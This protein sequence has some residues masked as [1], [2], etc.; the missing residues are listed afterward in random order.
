M[1]QVWQQKY[2]SNQNQSISQ[3]KNSKIQHQQIHENLSKNIEQKYQSNQKSKQYVSGYS[4]LK[5]AVQKAFSIRQSPRV[6]KPDSVSKL[7]NSSSKISLQNIEQLNNQN[8]Q[9]FYQEK[10]I[11]P[12]QHQ[13]FAKAI[14]NQLSQISHREIKVKELLGQSKMYQNSS[15]AS[16]A[17]DLR[18][19]QRDYYQ[20]NVN[21]GSSSFRLM[22]GRQSPENSCVIKM[23][24]INYHSHVQQESKLQRSQM[25]DS[26]G[27]SD[28]N[29]SH[30]NSPYQ[31]NL[32]SCQTS[33]KNTSLAVNQFD[34]AFEKFKQASNH[35]QFKHNIPVSM[36]Q[37]NSSLNS[38]RNYITPYKSTQKQEQ[39]YISTR[40]LER[41]VSQ[42][43]L[44]NKSKN[45]LEMMRRHTPSGAKTIRSSKSY[46]N[47][48][49]KNKNQCRTARPHQNSRLPSISSHKSLKDVH[50]KNSGILKFD[51]FQKERFGAGISATN[52]NK[53]I[54][55]Y[56]PIPIKD[57]SCQNF[58][59]G[60][61]FS[62]QRQSI[63]SFSPQKII[64]NKFQQ[65]NQL[66]Q[67]I[68][69][70]Q[71]QE[72]L[73][74]VEDEHEMKWHDKQHI[75][76]LQ[77]IQLLH[78][79]KSKLSTQQNH[80]LK[81][82]KLLPTQSEAMTSQNT[83]QLEKIDQIQLQRNIQ[84]TR[85]NQS[86]RIFSL[87]NPNSTG[88][89]NVTPL[90]QN[91]DHSQAFAYLSIGNSSN[92]LVQINEANSF[93]VAP[94]SN[95]S[96]FSYNTK[97]YKPNSN[98]N[99]TLKNSEQIQTMKEQSLTSSKTKIASHSDQINTKQ[100]NSNKNL[101]IQQ[102]LD[103]STNLE[104]SQQ[105]QNQRL[106][107][108]ENSQNI[109][110]QRNYS[111]LGGY[112]QNGNK[113]LKNQS[114]VDFDNVQSGDNHLA[115]YR[116]NIPQNSI[117]PPYGYSRLYHPSSTNLLLNAGGSQSHLRNR[118]SLL[119][120][121]QGDLSSEVIMFRADES[122]F[123]DELRNSN[124]RSSMNIGMQGQ[125]FSYK[126]KLDT[127][128]V[129]LSNKESEPIDYY[130]DL[131]NPSINS[132][133][134]TGH[135]NP[136]D[137]SKPQQSQIIFRNKIS[138]Q[139]SQKILQS[140]NPYQSSKFKVQNQQ[141]ISN[142]DNSKQEKVTLSLSKKQQVIKNA[143]SVAKITINDKK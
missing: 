56:S 49:S 100:V 81:I 16:Q 113:L 67:S 117:N 59:T 93:V 41:N 90:S 85:E 43:S 78:T 73:H 64:D 136:G 115:S 128:E 45:L 140:I 108:I 23:N 22:N 70:L 63:S 125:S 98:I 10:Q 141:K 24:S 51:S 53:I 55:D 32:R 105:N 3:S 46:E 75:N 37:R 89:D 130:E 18:K 103:V 106:S 92:N 17:Q 19:K 21:S 122:T 38:E 135:N 36:T 52:L 6:S 26:Q 142:N 94:A 102:N 101:N 127:L 2:Q 20:T 111:K 96:E 14:K 35:I 72:N 132:K 25:K 8:D 39:Q 74:T 99:F 79:Q 47:L 11:Q 61:F 69:S 68:E 4:P 76:C 95:I 129:I 1:S 7:G 57:I 29:M 30:Q 33:K 104:N 97:Y 62:S 88:C 15:N 137:S 107:Q 110:K 138:H 48:F 77:D 82:I 120:E 42:E 124:V 133:Q 65:K 134:L 86:T 114:I 126:D 5:K 31:L 44:R 109:N 123:N 28:R 9:R 83:P 40:N 58:K 60:K 66:N 27:T 84:Q 12:Q 118:D 80:E 119:K 121:S 87:H 116:C 139:T 54:D 91:I 71:S 34:V 131:I 143:K 50:D 13:T 112:V